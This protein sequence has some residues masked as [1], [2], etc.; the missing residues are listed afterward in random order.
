MQNLG[1]K[2]FADSA[3]GRLHT[4]SYYQTQRASFIRCVEMRSLLVGSISVMRGRT[5][6]AIFFFWQL[7]YG[8]KKLTAELDRFVCLVILSKIKTYTK[9]LTPT[10]TQTPKAVSVTN[11]LTTHT[12]AR[13]RTL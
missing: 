5:P 7:T 1:T 9:T 8:S 2:P 13:A 11:V 4:Q 6:G 3:A 10:L 12:R